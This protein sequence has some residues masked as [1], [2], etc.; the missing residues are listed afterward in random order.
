MLFLLLA[1]CST[2]VLAG[3]NIENVG[4]LQLLH[5]NNLF[6]ENNGTSAILVH[7]SRNYENAKEVCS[8]LGETLYDYES[9]SKQEKQEI[10]YQLDYLK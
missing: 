10:G 8:E 1:L 5:Y 7:E 2:T 9:T 3:V 6:P 4:T